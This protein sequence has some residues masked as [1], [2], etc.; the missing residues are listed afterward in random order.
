MV[1]MDAV[2]GSH[3][4]IVNTAVEAAITSIAS[5]VV[6]TIALTSL[7]SM[8]YLLFTYGHN[9]DSSKDD[10]TTGYTY[11]YECLCSRADR[12]E[13]YVALKDAQGC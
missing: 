8:V 4:A 9:S 12:K 3:E 5:F 1:S 10:Y 11:A 2:G 6:V 13:A 7:L